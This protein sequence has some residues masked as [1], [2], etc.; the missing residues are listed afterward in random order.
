M[1]DKRQEETEKQLP[2]FEQ[3][4]P[5]VI[6][7]IY[8]ASLSDYSGGRLHGA[9]LEVT[10]DVD[11]L[12]EGVEA[13]LASSPTPNCEEWAVHDYEGFGPMRLDEHE[14]LATLATIGAG[15]NEHG[16]AFA[17][18]AALVGIRDLDVLDGFEDAYLGQAESIESY[19]EQLL[20]DIGVFRQ[21]EDLLPEN[22]QPYLTFDVAGFARDL[23][24]S[25]DVVTSEAPEG[26]YVF[27]GA[28]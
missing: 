26:I 2:L 7:K 8:V 15:I 10:A 18:W 23:E 19:A 4:V 9:W 20:D 22:L 24:L 21:L 1:E 14:S 28:M 12:E 17:H 11:A 13:M 3:Q 16:R 5:K 6:P 25:G 27:S